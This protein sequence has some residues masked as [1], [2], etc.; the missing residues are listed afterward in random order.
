MYMNISG[1]AT[2]KIVEIL[3]NKS[4]PTWFQWQLW[5]TTAATGAFWT[6][7]KVD[8]LEG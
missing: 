5:M 6:V 2:N 4:F 8:S 1:T 7:L 3:W